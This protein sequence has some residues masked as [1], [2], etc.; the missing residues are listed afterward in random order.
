NELVLSELG[1][2]YN[3]VN[4][5]TNS[6]A[7]FD[8]SILTGADESDSG[9]GDENNGWARYTTPNTSAVQFVWTPLL[10]NQQWH[11]WDNLSVAFKTQ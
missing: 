6:G 10:S 11:L 1:V 5:V 3:T 4:G 8:S 9:D 2:Y 7:L